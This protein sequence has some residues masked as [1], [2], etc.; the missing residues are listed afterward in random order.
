MS[1]IKKINEELTE[2]FNNIG[3]EVE[4]VNL[5]PSGRK[6]LGDYQINDAMTLAKKYH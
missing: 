3:Y 5:Q 6:D 4:Q 1:I 2:I